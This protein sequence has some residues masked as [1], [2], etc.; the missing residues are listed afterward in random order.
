[1]SG[2]QEKGAYRGVGRK[3]GVGKKVVREGGGYLTR[4][5]EKGAYSPKERMWC[6]KDGVLSTGSRVRGLSWQ[7]WKREGGL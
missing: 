3:R 2:V 4:V 1:L 7:N 5:P 6:G